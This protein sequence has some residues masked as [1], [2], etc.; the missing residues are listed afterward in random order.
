VRNEK[1]SRRVELSTGELFDTVSKGDWA[2]TSGMG[3]CYA[4][5]E[6][7]MTKPAAEIEDRRVVA[8]RC[9]DALCAAYP[10]K[11]ITLIQPR[12]ADAPSDVTAASRASSI[13]ILAD[14][15]GEGAN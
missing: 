8:K 15:D 1:P 4:R 13:R 10:D 7:V 11:Y 6:P 9:F 5:T 12:E 3:K 14:P 2:Q